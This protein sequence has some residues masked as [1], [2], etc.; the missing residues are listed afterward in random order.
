MN[1]RILAVAGGLF[2]LLGLAATPAYADC[3]TDIKELEQRLSTMQQTTR[4]AHKDNAE[5]LMAE[6]KQALADGKKK[7]CAKKVKAANLQADKIQ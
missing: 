3:A 1:K 5:R 7:K 4:A 2:M 6:A